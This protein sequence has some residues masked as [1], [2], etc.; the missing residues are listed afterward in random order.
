MS[1]TCDGDI[2]CLGAGSLRLKCYRKLE[3]TAKIGVSDGFP[4]NKKAYVLAAY[5]VWPHSS[6][7]GN[8]PAT[9]ALSSP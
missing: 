8:P 2:L 1:Q 4:R 9:Y 3:P 5:D 6:S 7:E